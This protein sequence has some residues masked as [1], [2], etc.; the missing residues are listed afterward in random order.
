[1]PILT[2]GTCEYDQELWETAL[3]PVPEPKTIHC[4]ICH[5]KITLYSAWEN[6]CDCGALYNGFGQHLAPRSQWGEETG[7]TF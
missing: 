6:E 1:M 7:E 3:R 5:R 4:C 2:D